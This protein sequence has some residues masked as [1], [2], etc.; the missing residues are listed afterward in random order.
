MPATKKARVKAPAPSKKTAKKVTPPQKAKVAAKAVAVKKAI[1]VKKVADSKTHSGLLLEDFFAGELK[2]IYWAENHLLKVLPKMSKNATSGQLKKAFDDH[3]KVTEGHVA[4]LENIFELMG[5]KAQGK[6]CEAMA[7]ITKEGDEII[8]E[9]AKGTE[10]RDA[11]LVLAAKKVEH[12]E[13][14]TY[15]GLAAIAR[16]LGKNNIAVI[17]EQTLAEEKEAD[18]TLSDLGRT[19][20]NVEASKETDADAGDKEPGFFNKVMEVLGGHSH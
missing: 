3:K 8:D 7:G 20:V 11:G 13:I 14:A 15:A 16:T 18:Q 2:D 10:T 17:L 4:R 5:K 1:P 9:T 6:K 12:Y 19:K